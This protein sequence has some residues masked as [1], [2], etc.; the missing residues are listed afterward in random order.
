MLHRRIKISNGKEFIVNPYMSFTFIHCDLVFYTENKF[1]FVKCDSE[2]AISHDDALLLERKGIGLFEY[3]RRI[4]NDPQLCKAIFNWNNHTEVSSLVDLVGNNSGVGIDIGCGYGRLLLPLT[5][6]GLKLDGIDENPFLIKDLSQN[7]PQGSKTSLFC[8]RIQDF[9]CF[10]K[11][12]FAIS[13]L[14]TIR[15]LETKWDF[16][17]HMN[18]MYESLEPKAIY[19]INCSIPKF[20]QVKNK[21]TW[22]FDHQN[23]KYT[24][25]WSRDRF[26]YFTEQI[27]DRIDI[28][29]FKTG[30]LLLTEFQSQA[31]FS[32]TFWK[33]FISETTQWKL[34]ALLDN[35]FKRVDLES[36]LN[37]T[38]WFVLKRV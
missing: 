11:Y 14:N 25:N 28:Y 29:N 32:Q 16:F 19:L 2:G 27:T 4:F 8:A 13:A 26:N 12:N 5:N 23:E 9:Q 33:D 21:I 17:R 36:E 10:S 6:R 20:P 24:I 37:G 34:D 18:C 35:H 15:Y 3:S 22:H 1:L 38:Y 7:L 31:H 30:K